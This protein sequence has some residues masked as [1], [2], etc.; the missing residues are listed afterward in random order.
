[1]HLQKVNT[2]IND[3][4]NENHKILINNIRKN[5]II[6]FYNI[7]LNNQPFEKSTFRSLKFFQFFQFFFQKNTYIITKLTDAKLKKIVF[8]NRLK[9]YYFCKTIVFEISSKN[10]NLKFDNFALK[11]DQQSIH[12][13]KKKFNI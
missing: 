3:F 9:K 13:E 4:F 6:M 1:M 11:N 10:A 12:F 7:R 5:N 8:N 2:K